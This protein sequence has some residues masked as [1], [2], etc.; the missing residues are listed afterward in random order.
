[1]ENLIRYYFNAGY[2]ATEIAK[3]ISLAHGTN[4]SESYLRKRLVKLNLRRKSIEED[5]PEVIHAM[6]EELEGTGRCLGY[7][8]MWSRLKKKYGLSVKRDTVMQLLQLMDP[9]GVEQ[10]S[11][12]GLRRR[13]YTNNGPLYL[14]HIDGYDK[15]KHFGFAIHGAI[16]G[17]SRK[18][19]WLRVSHTNN[20]PEVIGTYFLNFIKEIG[21]VPRV[22]RGDRGTENTMVEDLQK[23]CRWNSTDNMSGEKSFLYGRSTS[24]QR[25]ERWWL[26]LRQST[27]QF[28]MDFFRNMEDQA[29]FSSDN[30]LQKEIIR[31][32]FMELI[33]KNLDRA[34]MEWNTHRIRPSRRSDC[35]SGIPNV[36]FFTP[37][38]YGCR[39]YKTPVSTEDIDRLEDLYAV[40]LK[41]CSSPELQR[42]FQNSF[43]NWAP[44]VSSNAALELYVHLVNLFNGH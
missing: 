24:N 5:I 25:I 16:D 41:I 14:V 8:G 20:D 42:A 31:F 43:A 3:T 29:L 4:V 21:G 19:L 23:A 15:L 27:I 6:R 44:P 12:R 38:L 1:M 33:Q 2:T 17:F 39:D 34:A 40:P 30:V 28:W 9:A 7:R 11:R 26:E 13:D 32:C 37:S 10:R 36:M 22:I 18:V 35:P